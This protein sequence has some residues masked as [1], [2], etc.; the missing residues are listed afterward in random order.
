M[1][2]RVSGYIEHAKNSPNCEIVAGGTYDDS[3]GFYVQPTIVQTNTPTDKTFTE[4]IFGPLVSIY[5]YPDQVLDGEMH[6]KKF[7]KER[8]RCQHNDWE[9]SLSKERIDFTT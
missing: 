1:Y 5:V 7:K 3:V 4:E 8:K 2:I 6:N 9:T